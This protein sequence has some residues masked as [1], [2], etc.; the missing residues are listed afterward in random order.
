MYYSK[1]S[2]RGEYQ[3]FDPVFS[4]HSSKEST[5]GDYQ[6]FDPVFFVHFSKE[7]TRGEYQAFDPVFFLYTLLKSQQERS[8]IRSLKLII[9]I[10]SLKMSL[11]SLK[12]WKQTMAVVR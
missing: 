7:S 10:I 3:A 11:N 1:Q 2:A 9:M 8:I 5:R 4:V 6:A 12:I